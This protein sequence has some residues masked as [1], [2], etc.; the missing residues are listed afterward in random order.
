MKRC[1]RSVLCVVLSCLLLSVLPSCGSDNSSKL[2]VYNLSAEP[3][4]L[5]PPLA[6]DAASALVVTNLFEGLLRMGEGGTVTEG[7]AESYEVSDDGLRYVFYLRKDAKW[8]DETP[9]TADDFVFGFRRLF[10]PKTGS[11]S[12]K[13]L[14]CIKNAKA[15]HEGALPTDALGVSASDPHTLVIELDSVN[16]RFLT[17]LTT[18]AA[19]PCNEAFFKE[20]KGRYGLTAETILSNG[21]YRLKEWAAGE[22]LALRKNTAYHAADAVRNGGISLFIEEDPAVTL[23]AFQKDSVCAISCEADGI[24]SLDTAHDTVEESLSSVWGILLN[25]EGIL[26]D[27]HLTKALLYGMDRS[28]YQDVLP[29]YLV[30]ADAIIPPAVTIQG[31]GYRE[32]LSSGVAA[33]AYQPDR[34]RQEIK[35]GYEA[36]GVSSLTKLRM[37]VPESLTPHAELFSYVSQIWQENLRVYFVVETL[38]EEEY[39]AR[40]EA[41]DYDCAVVNLQ[42]SYDAPEAFLSQFVQPGKAGYPAGTEELLDRAAKSDVETAAGLYRQAEQSILDSGIFL[43]LYYQTG[44]F[45]TSASVTGFVH[46][47]SN[48]VIDFKNCVF[49]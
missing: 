16:T 37:I 40:L 19:M 17:L 32:K 12:A 47:F 25:R 7:A 34:A 38:E 30:S 33:P 41:G 21:A 26:A 46:D 14:Y 2:L 10:D 36:L 49:S 15:V 35:A 45:V 4:N 13:N 29:P 28:G 24:S 6:D 44:Y 11:V 39:N 1:I 3:V 20:S 8:S 48:Q 22:Y 18:P 42:A 43:P 31:T 9:L 23:E 5:D 27:D